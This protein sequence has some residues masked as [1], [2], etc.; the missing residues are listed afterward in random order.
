MVIIN[1]FLELVAYS[2]HNKVPQTGGLNNKTL[3]CCTSGSWESTTQVLAELVLSEVC[4]RES[5]PFLF[6]SFGW[7]A[8][9]LWYSLAYG[10]PSSYLYYVL[11]L[12]VSVF[13]YPSFMWISIIL[14]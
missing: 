5:V 14:D 2:C 12:C 4:E 7:L 10:S 9:D 13:K 1:F 11:S 3:L 6:P 8:G